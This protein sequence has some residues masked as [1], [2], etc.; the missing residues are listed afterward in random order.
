MSTFKHGT[1]GYKFEAERDK[2]LSLMEDV[3]QLR[4][5]NNADNL[6]HAHDLELNRK[7]A[8]ES[9][10]ALHRNLTTLIHHQLEVAPQDIEGH[11]LPR[12]VVMYTT[13]L[14]EV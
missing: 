11:E 12:E 4:H 5:L 14:Q 6:Q 3:R 8:A 13:P 9:L 7:R 1:T 2:V 10:R